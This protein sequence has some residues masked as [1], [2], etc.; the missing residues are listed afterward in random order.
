[1]S[2]P[3]WN[4]LGLLPDGIHVA[5]LADIYDR[6]VLDAPQRDARENLYSALTAYLG[7]LRE[8]VPHGKAWIDG[9]FMMCKDTPPHDVDLVFFPDDWNA[10][11]SKGEAEAAELFSLLT[12]QNVL[13]ESPAAT[14]ARLQP[15]GGKIDAFIA[16]PRDAAY[17]RSL[18]SSVKRHGHPVP[19]ETKGFA[20]VTW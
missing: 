19:S 18:W 14:F 16:R 5:N 1:M 11:A 9:G 20:E 6:C 2:L 8:I 3:E 10:L 15:F 17:W 7:F 13:C 12:L 4:D